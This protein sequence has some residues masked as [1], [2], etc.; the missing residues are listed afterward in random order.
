MLLNCL[1]SCGSKNTSSSKKH[2]PMVIEELCHHFSLADLRR[3][4]NNFDEKLIIGKGRYDTVYKGCLEHN[5]ATDHIVAIKRFAWN[6]DGFNEFKKE[7]ELLCQLRHPNLVSLIGFYNHKDEKIIVYE[8]TS[9]GIL[10]NYMH[11]RD[12]EPLSWKKRLEICIGA[13]RGLHYLH[14]G[15]KRS[16]F[17]RDIKPGNILLDNNMVPKISYFGLALQGPP[18]TSKPKPIAA[19]NVVGDCVFIL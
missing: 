17:H 9:T 6:F 18:S 8:Y 4:T 12:K 13:A 14:S 2:Y 7:I 11:N 15:A 16:I 10:H 3:S 19:D 1:G 5:G